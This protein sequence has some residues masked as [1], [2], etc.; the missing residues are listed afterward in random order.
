MVMAAA[1]AAPK[2]K[3]K[4]KKKATQMIFSPW[5]GLLAQ[6]VSAGAMG[7]AQAW[8]R[9]VAFLRLPRRARWVAYQRMR[10]MGFPCQDISVVGQHLGLDGSR[11]S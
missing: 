10:K 3:A 5:G 8:C 1:K 9:W 7:R 2:A 11:S 6:S 4:T